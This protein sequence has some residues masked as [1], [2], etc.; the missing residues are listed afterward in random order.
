MNKDDVEDEIIEFIEGLVDAEKSQVKPFPDSESEFTAVTTKNRFYVGFHAADYAKPNSTAE[1]SQIV[2]DKIDVWLISKKRRGP[3]GINGMYQ[4]I[5][6]NVIGF[7][8]GNAGRLFGLKFE[9]HDRING[10]FFYRFTLG[11]LIKYVQN[12]TP[13]DGPNMSTLE[14]EYKPPTE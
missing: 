14:F 11:S 7:T 9:F 5:T 3:D 10:A 4:L 2:T 13:T 1:T 6:D 8:P 12:Y